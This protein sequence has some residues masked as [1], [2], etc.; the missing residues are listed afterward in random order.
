MLGES[1][2]VTSTV[3]QVEQFLARVRGDVKGDADAVHVRTNLLRQG[4]ALVALLK[5]SRHT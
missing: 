4:E 3:A 5:A 2:S 1:G